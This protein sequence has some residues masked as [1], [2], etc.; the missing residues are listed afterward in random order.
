MVTPYNNPHEGKEV[1]ETISKGNKGGVASQREKVIQKERNTQG[2]SIL[3]LMEEIVRVG[4]AMGYKMDGC[5]GHKSKK[6]WVRELCFKNNVNFV[7]LQETKMECV[8]LFTLKKLWGNF[9]FDNAISPSVGNSGEIVCMWEPSIFVKENVIVFDSFLLITGCWVPSGTKILIISVYA[10]QDIVGKRMLWD[11]LCHVKDNWNGECIIMG[12]F[13][14]VRTKE[15]RFGSKFNSQ[16]AFIFNNFILSAGLVDIPLGGYSF[17]WAH[18]TA[19]KMSKLDRFLISDGLLT[20]FPH[21]SDLCLDRHLSDHR[22]ILLKETYLDYGAILF[23]FISFVV[24][25]GW[26]L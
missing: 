9:S 24:S 14:E 11:C 26:L 7:S 10:P 1:N 22:L 15:E 17:M 8:D 25:N 2:G 21:L 12:D 5:L 20:L 4:Q 23:S 3:N 19:T 16:D 13:N 6:R 18:K